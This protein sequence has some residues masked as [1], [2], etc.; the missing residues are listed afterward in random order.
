MCKIGR[1]LALPELRI[2]LVPSEFDK[3]IELCESVYVY[4]K[5]DRLPFIPELEKTLKDKSEA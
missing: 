1:H 2:D 4:V 3:I 5:P